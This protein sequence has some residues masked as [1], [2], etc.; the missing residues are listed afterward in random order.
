MEPQRLWW[1]RAGESRST[2]IPT[3]VPVYCAGPGSLLTPAFLGCVR[4]CVKGR[5]AQ[6]HCSHVDWLVTA[7]AKL[8]GNLSASFH[9]VC[10]KSGAGGRF[11]PWKL[12][13]ATDKGFVQI[14]RPLPAHPGER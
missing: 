13:N 11:T 8:S 7:D 10:L 4:H 14:L 3:L 5:G 2:G 12:A 9:V 6:G 1:E